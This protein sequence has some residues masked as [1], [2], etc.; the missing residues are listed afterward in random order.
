MLQR[1]FFVSLAMISLSACAQGGAS[2]LD[3]TG[4]GGTPDASIRL[5]ASSLTDAGRLPDSGSSRDSGA[6]MRDAGTISCGAGQHACGTGCVDDLAN[7]PANG[8]RLGCGEPCTPP[9]GGVSSCAESGTCDFTCNPPFTRVGATCACTP[10]TCAEA[11]VTCGAPDDGCGHP[12]DCGS[13]G[14]NE[15][16]EGRCACDP[17][18]EEPNESGATPAL[19]DALSDAPDS[20]GVYEELNLHSAEDVDWV[21]FEIDDDFDLKN[22]DITVTLDGVPAGS[23]YE[24]S[25][26]YSCTNESGGTTCLGGTPT[27]DPGPGC[28]ATASGAAG[29]V[30]LATRCGGLTDDASGSV[31]VRIRSTTWGGLC[32]P[33]RLRVDVR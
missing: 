23:T 20:S 9:S 22:P 6:P 33:Y 4:T 3:E 5:D 25:A 17:D 27:S 32:N 2:L 8:C 31:F 16:V 24:L 1:L 14:G 18:G 11:D 29:E 28:T 13:C 21:Y 15:C 10:R 12:L 26:F 19:L 30:R 7:E